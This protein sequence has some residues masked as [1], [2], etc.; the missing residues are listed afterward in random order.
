MAK[1]ALPAAGGES[2]DLNLEESL[3]QD[4]GD[5]MR[6]CREGGGTWQSHRLGTAGLRHTPRLW[7]KGSGGVPASDRAERGPGASLTARGVGAGQSTRA[8]VTPPTAPA[9]APRAPG[10]RA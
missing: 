3:P 2:S 10:D 7:E 4:G 6:P 1:T 8:A 9:P 5:G